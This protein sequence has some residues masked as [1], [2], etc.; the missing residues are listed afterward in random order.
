MVSGD[1]DAVA[2]LVADCQAGDIRA[3]K[4]AA[5]YAC[6][7]AHVE[8]VRDQLLAALSDVAPDAS[9]VPFY[10]TVTGGLLD[11]RELNAEHWYRN[12]RQTVQLEQ[13]IQSVHEDGYRFFVEISPHPLLTGDIQETLDAGPRRPVQAVLASSLGRS[14]ATTVAGTDFSPPSARCSWPGATWT[15]GPR[16]PGRRRAG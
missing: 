14:A 16:S 3:R 8:P 12:A 15:G 11:T 4:I 10:S 6:H 9:D 7:S 1:P 5:Q 2:E 13:T